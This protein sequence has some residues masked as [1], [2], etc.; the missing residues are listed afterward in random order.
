MVWSNIS[1]AGCKIK[2]FLPSAV[3]G[4]NTVKSEGKTSDLLYTH[5]KRLKKLL[6]YMSKE[7]ETDKKIS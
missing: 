6:I 4:E 3:C 5:I 1:N 2:H 7:E